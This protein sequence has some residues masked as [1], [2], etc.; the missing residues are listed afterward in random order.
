MQCSLDGSC[1]TSKTVTITLL[2]G[3]KIIFASVICCDTHWMAL[4]QNY[5]WWPCPTFKMVSKSSDWLKIGNIQQSSSEALDGM[6]QNFNKKCLD[7]SLLKLYELTMH[8]FPRWLLSS[9]IVK[10]EAFTYQVSNHKQSSVS[11]HAFNIHML[12]FPYFV[13]MLLSYHASHGIA[14]F[15]V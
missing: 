2:I 10:H 3:W 8:I 15:L 12:N 9:N 4:F 7:G 5:V 11:T 1:P 13:N 14:P 6:K